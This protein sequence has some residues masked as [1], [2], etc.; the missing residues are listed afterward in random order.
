MNDI[1]KQLDE[2]VDSY[3]SDLINTDISDVKDHKYSDK[4][5]K[6]IEEAF[7]MFEESKKPKP[8]KL[9]RRII[10]SL[11]AAAL[12]GTI[13]VA[14]YEP[15][16]RFF[17]NLFSDHTE[18]TPAENS[19]EIDKHKATIENK[20]SIT[21][22]AG[23]VLD[24]E[25]TAET[26]KMIIQTYTIGTDPQ[27]V[28]I[29]KQ[30]TKELYS[31]SVDNKDTELVTKLDKNGREILIHSYKDLSTSIIWDNG[32]YIF[33]LSGEMPESELMDIYYTAK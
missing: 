28:L 8:H 2:I 17:I 12:I 14:A 33:E 7:A 9:R 19:S 23:Y 30:L 18:V 20:Y 5:N 29:F 13:T 10:I 27:R 4:F 1:Q 24:K 6:K 22:P 3:Y 26:D 11:I 25:S 31:V 32:E 16:R 15:A 21:V